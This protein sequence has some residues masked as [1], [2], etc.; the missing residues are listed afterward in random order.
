MSTTLIIGQF[1]NWSRHPISYTGDDVRMTSHPSKWLTHPG[2]CSMWFSRA[3]L[4]S[5][6]VLKMDKAIVEKV[7]GELVSYTPREF[8]ARYLDLATEPLVVG[9]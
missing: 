9:G 1:P 5:E 7:R 4:A 2:L 8:L 6:L 3:G